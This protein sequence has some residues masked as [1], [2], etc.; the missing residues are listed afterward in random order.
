MSRMAA[1]F[2]VALALV[3]LGCEGPAGKTGEIGPTGATGPTGPALEVGDGGVAQGVITASCLSPCH[4]F[5]GIVDQYRSSTHYAA[6]VANLGGQEVPTWTGTTPCGNCHAID[7]LSLRAQGQVLSP[8]GTVSSI[9]QGH[10]EYADT[11]KSNALADSLYAGSAKVAEVYCTTCHMVTEANDPHKTGAVYTPGTFGFWVATGAAD[12]AYLEKSPAAGSVVGQPAGN[13]GTGNVCI[14][15]HKA[16]KDVRNYIKP[17]GVTLNNPYW[18]P[19]E[20]PQADVYTGK[21]GYEFASKTY[22]SSTHTSF[23]DGCITCHMP[24][25]SVNGDYPN[26]SFYA[27]VSA[28]QAC[29]AGATSFDVNGAQTQI[30]AALTELEALLNSAGYLSRATT[31][32]DMP[33]AAKDL[34]SN[35]QLDQTRSAPPSTLDQDTAGALWNYIIIARGG[36]LG[37]HNPTYTR[38]LLFDSIEKVKG[39]APTSI[40]TRP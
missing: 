39:S 38:Q 12:A 32:A 23:E 19:H 8:G 29:H 15:C 33:V 2:V 7:A 14:Y 22:A 1:L 5:T 30:T 18:G 11:T 6:F 28:C 40:T 25:A 34:G 3:A 4:S 17:A 10:L 35:F 13:Y 16:R 37:V 9:E 24:P 36:A 21:G 27:Q 31:G 20:G 26:H